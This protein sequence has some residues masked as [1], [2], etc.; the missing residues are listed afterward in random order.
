MGLLSDRDRL[1]MAATLGLVANAA[2]LK[3]EAPGTIS[4]GGD[5]TALTTVWEGEAPGFL[6]RTLVD[7]PLRGPRR[8]GIPLD[9][10]QQMHTD[11]FTFLDG[12]AT[13]IP[14]AGPDWKNS[15]VTIEDRRGAAPVTVVMS[16]I[17]AEHQAY[18]LLDSTRLV[19]DKTGA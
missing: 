15:T 7:Q 11:V 3:I 18:G 1:G 6:S 5:V 9:T 19:L 2:L 8:D 14:E 4:A 13:A 12:V 10:D 17:E 16:V